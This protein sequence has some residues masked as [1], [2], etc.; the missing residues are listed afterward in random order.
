MHN[1]RASP[2]YASRGA[3]EGDEMRED[4]RASEGRTNADDTIRPRRRD[5]ANGRIGRG[6]EKTL[7]REGT[8]PG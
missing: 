6:R 7:Y 3:G 8:Q 5:E 2:T 4:L 1:A